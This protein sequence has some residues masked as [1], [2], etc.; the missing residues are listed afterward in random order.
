MHQTTIIQLLIV[1]AVIL[2]TTASGL[3]VLLRRQA[4]RAREESFPAIWFRYMRVT[5]WMM[6]G[7]IMSWLW[8][9]FSW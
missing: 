9:W 4:E 2:F 6:F 1:A 8:A 5:N 3:G 7:C